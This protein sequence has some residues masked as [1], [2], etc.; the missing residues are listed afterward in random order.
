MKRFLYLGLGKDMLSSKL[1]RKLLCNWLEMHGYVS[2]WENSKLL[3]LVNDKYG[4]I[5]LQVVM[6]ILNCIYF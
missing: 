5:H 1:K 4:L 2:I 3:L 6:I